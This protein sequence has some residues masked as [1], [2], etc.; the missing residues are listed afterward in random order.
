[1]EAWC[2]EL[3][4]AALGALGFSLIFNVR[5][6]LL[7]YTAFGGFLAWGI[8]LLLQHLGLEPVVSYLLSSIMITV[9]A[10]ICARLHKAPATVFLVTSVITLVPGS[11]LYATMVYAVHLRWEDFFRQG[12]E[13]LLL[14][15]AISAGVLIVSTVMHAFY[16]A[17]LRTHR[18]G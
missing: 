13:T 15:G 5:G 6:R 8:N 18:A 2:V 11:K 10:E 1:M 3:L 7:L 12:L 9:Y 14:A 4:T 16:A 17:R